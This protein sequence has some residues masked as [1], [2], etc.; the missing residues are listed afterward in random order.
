VEIFKAFGDR[1]K[2]YISND[3]KDDLERAKENP[4]GQ[5][6][7]KWCDAYAVDGKFGDCEKCP[8]CDRAV[9]M[10]KWLEPR[11]IRLTNTKYPDRLTSWLPQSIVVSEHVVQAYT[12]EGLRGIR[13]FI[14]IEVVSVS[15]RTKNS[16]PPPKYFVAEIEYTLN[17]RVDTAN[18][19]VAG[20]K[21]DWSCVLCNPWG[22]TCDQLSK[23]S[24]NAEKWQGEDVFKVYAAGVI[25]SQKF[26]NLIEKYEFTNFNLV[27]VEKYKIG[28]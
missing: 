5:Y 27:P 22:T 1:M 4:D 14:P 23:L 3:F 26:Y 6:V 25:F 24:L 21:H 11:K 15:R 28:C 10:L 12:E 19:I 18:T 7:W 9:S 2:F 8:Q 20:S 17:V 16:L 13:K